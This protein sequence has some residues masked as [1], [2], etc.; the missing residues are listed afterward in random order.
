MRYW[1]Y[2][3]E[4][5][6]GPVA[7]SELSG[8]G[9][10]ALVCGEGISGYEDGDWKSLEDIPELA[11]F[12]AAAVMPSSALSLHDEELLIESAA[13]GYPEEASPGRLFDS[14]I[15][16]VPAPRS[17]DPAPS[18][19]FYFQ[20]NDLLGRMRDLEQRQRELLDQ[21]EHRLELPAPVPAPG[22]PGRIKEPKRFEGVPPPVQPAPAAEP[23]PA[24]VHETAFE[25]EGGERPNEALAAA[26]ALGGILGNLSGIVPEVVPEA[27]AEPPAAP[28]KSRRW[29]VAADS[30]PVAKPETEPAKKTLLKLAP[31]KKFS[32]IGEPGKDD[33]LAGA[34][35]YPASPAEGGGLPAASMAPSLH[36]PENTELVAAEVA[37]PEPEE[38]VD[39]VSP[40]HQEALS[41]P[42]QPM[43]PLSEPIK[44]APAPV[45]LELPKIAAAPVPPMVEA[46]PPP[47]SEPIP[48]P[49]SIPLPLPTPIA[50]PV[51]HS[52]M[53]PVPTPNL[54]D[55]VKARPPGSSSQP[56][57]LPPA[58]APASVPP[59]TMRFAV[60]AAP[61]AEA[62]A[63][64]NQTTATEE[65]ISRL[66]KHS[67]ESKSQPPKPK[68]RPTKTFAIAIGSAVLIL[69]VLFFFFF[70]NTKEIKLLFD[71]GEPQAP[72]AAGAEEEALPVLEKPKIA[73]APAAEPAATA[74]AQVP[75]EAPVP[76][77]AQP[78]VEDP[79]PLAIETVRNYV[80]SGGRGTIAEN[81]QSSFAGS[82]GEPIK[83]K[84][85]AGAL[86]ATTFM[87]QYTVLPQGNQGAAEPITYIFVVDIQNKT[88]KGNNP[89]A[90]KLM[91]DSAA[92][93]PKARRVLPRKTMPAAKK[94][95]RA[96]GT[97]I[98]ET[99]GTLE[100]PAEEAAE[101]TGDVIE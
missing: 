12:R 75:A 71:M 92:P 51:A 76:P 73:Q 15:S 34:E 57:A 81:L 90:K 64:I 49:Q 11:E 97:L 101:S 80:L 38:I 100:P 45:S 6:I 54:G 89:T 63:K 25:T 56:G 70:R 20:V 95:P 86:D 68:R 37:V 7:R 96:A 83:D 69:V 72:L 41:E 91:Q 52:R 24:V 93:K 84:W 40:G 58:S 27:A 85:N 66:A 35:S 74:Q 88:V 14:F 48:S 4:K 5:I 65:V 46:S 60:G 23:P 94:E 62:G 26:E 61:G 17:V 44:P 32:V 8:L 77:A 36:P 98:P 22:I 59:M 13:L 33:S 16:G 42:L 39:V 1:V 82:T 55:L 67:D 10:G 47:L 50:A 99:A 28:I 19:E 78:L 43:E 31:P 30:W 53:E 29:S 18:S 79:T 21:L 3:N 87:V 9:G 2:K